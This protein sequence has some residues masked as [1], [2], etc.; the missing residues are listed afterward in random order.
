MQLSVVKTDG[1]T[2]QY[3]YTKVIGTFSN[4]LAH[5]D[6]PDLFAAEQFAETITF[7]LYQTNNTAAITSAEIHMMVLSVLKST[8]HE[9]AAKALDEHHLTRK[10]KRKRIEVV[11]DDSDE[12]ICRWDKSRIVED[13][14]EEKKLSRQTARMIAS[15]V[16]QKALNIGMTR[17]RRSLIKQLVIADMETI[18]RA[19]NQLLTV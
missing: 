7:Y 2:E 9:N 11:G 17:I 13:L 15:A 18:L 8:G 4:A 6:E 16:E 19:E 3:M 12:S 5:L 10:L 1:S 14:V